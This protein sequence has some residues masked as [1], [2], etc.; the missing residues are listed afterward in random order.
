[1]SLYNRNADNVVHGLHATPGRTTRQRRCLPR[2]PKASSEPPGAYCGGGAFWNVYIVHDG[3]S[4]RSYFF[5][6]DAY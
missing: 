6:N 4:I 2:Q 1:M 5:Q 3:G